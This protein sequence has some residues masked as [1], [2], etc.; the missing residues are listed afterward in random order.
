MEEKNAIKNDKK[1]IHKLSKEFEKRMEYECINIHEVK[2]D[3]SNEK[4]MKNVKF[5]PEQADALANQYNMGA[6]GKCKD[7][8]KYKKLI[9]Q[10]IE[11]K[12][13]KMKKT[14]K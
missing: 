13:K 1:Q 10:Q 4:K 8:E 7:D 5:T 3:Y 2:E 14:Q 9:L 11:E 12:V 6:S